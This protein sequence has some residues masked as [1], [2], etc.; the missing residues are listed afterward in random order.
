MAWWPTASASEGS[1]RASVVACTTALV[2]G[3]PTV[4]VT[5]DPRIRPEAKTVVD[6]KVGTKLTVISKNGIA[7]GVVVM[8][9]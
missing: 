4:T 3:S 9:S 8:P 2:A 6:L 7:T 5:S 1:S